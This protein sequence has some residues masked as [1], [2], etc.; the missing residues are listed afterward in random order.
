MQGRQTG[1]AEPVA[2]TFPESLTPAALPDDDLL[3]DGVYESLRFDDLDLS[4]RV[5]CG[6]EID[7]CNFSNV[8][9][10]GARL[11]RA[12]V[13]DTVLDRC[14]LANLRARESS[15]IRVVLSA[16]RMTGLSWLDGSFRDTRFDNCRMDLVSLRASTFADVVFTDCKCE[17]ADFGAA[18]L[19]GARFERCDL[20]AAQFNEAQLTGTRFA[21]CNL[22]DIGGVTSMRGA[23]I[24]STDALALTFILASALG[25]TIEDD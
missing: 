12:V 4:G 25:I 13:R 6:A 24:K 9:F 23:I 14:D 10:S 17:Q 7:Q 1:F 2:P 21:N 16:S 20:T 19:R 11:D 8:S 15:L 18:D 3:D 5:V 22:T